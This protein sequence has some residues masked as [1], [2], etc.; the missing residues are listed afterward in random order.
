M[1]RT[2]NEEY[3]AIQL[4]VPVAI[5]ATAVTTGVAVGDGKLDD[6]MVIMNT[7]AVSGTAPTLTTSVQTSDLVS[8]TYTTVAAFGTVSAASKLGAVRVNLEGLNSGGE[9]QKFVRLS[10]VVTGT[11]TPLVTAGFVLLLRTE[12]P[13]N[14]LNPSTPA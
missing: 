11:S 8:G 4:A 6:A 10:H 3:I 2:V 9:E 13:K 7:G 1:S 5:G 12:R 14:A